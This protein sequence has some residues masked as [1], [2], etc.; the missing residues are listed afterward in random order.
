[1]WREGQLLSNDESVRELVYLTL[2]DNKKV[3]AIS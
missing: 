2:P 3:A 1:M